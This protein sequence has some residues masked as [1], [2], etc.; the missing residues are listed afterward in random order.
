MRAIVIDDSRAMRMILRN[1]LSELGHES[2]EAT[3]GQEGLDAVKQH[4]PFELALVD[5]NMPVMNG[6]DFV[7]A[8]RSDPA[9]DSMKIMMVTTEIE[10]SQVTKALEAG[11]N[12]YVMKPFTKDALRDKLELLAA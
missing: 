2:V 9:N 3:N 10:T 5:W 6:Y 8:V 11:A 4:G 1:V 7:K 12:E